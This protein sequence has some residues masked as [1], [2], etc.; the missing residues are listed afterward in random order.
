MTPPNYEEDKK[1]KQAFVDMVQLELG[2]KTVNKSVP[3]WMMPG[4][5]DGVI[6]IH[7]GY[8]RTLGGR[9]A[10]NHGF[11]AYDIRTFGHRPGLRPACGSN[12]TG[13]R[14]VLATTQAAFQLEDRDFRNEAATSC[15]EYSSRNT[16][17]TKIICAK[18]K[19]I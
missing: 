17:T 12:K 4:Q 15:V 5:P 13:Q 18:S 14:Y 3:D 10:P 9:V 6:T 2:D 19:R 11:N 16:S 1:G 8:G 7:L